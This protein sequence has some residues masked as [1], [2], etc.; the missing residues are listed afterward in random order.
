M[1]RTLPDFKARAARHQAQLGEAGALRLLQAGRAWNLAPVLQAGGSILFPHTTLAVCGHQ[2]ASAVHA[3]LHS[4]AQRVI[5]LGVL[6]ALTE[7]MAQARAR[8]AE[9]ADPAN[10][11]AWGLQGPGMPARQDWRAEFSLDHFLFLWE[12]AVKQ[13]GT[14]APE[15]VVRYPC[16]VGDSPDRLPGIDALQEQAQGA[17]VVATMDPFHHGI[18]Y[19]DSPQTALLPEAG[20]LALARERIAEGME[21]LRRGDYAGYLR[22]CVRSRSDG[23]DVGPVL[24]YLLGPVEGEILDLLAD[25]MTGP[26]QAQAPTWVAGALL[27]LHKA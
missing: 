7:E 4:G 8:V 12:H 16:L 9:G 26:Y 22:H 6:H 14:P 1:R 23:R 25:D 17:V 21:L 27:A 15:L 18:G 24:R 20:G 10:E 19:G 2:I 13:Q 11:P 3:C 5:V